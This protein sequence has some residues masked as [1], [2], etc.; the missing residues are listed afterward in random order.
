[1]SFPKKHFIAWGFICGAVAIIL[2][3][4][5]ESEKKID[6]LFLIKTSSISITSSEFSEELDLKRAAYPYNI[7]G[8]PEEYNEMVM[9]LIQSLS[10]ELV[11]LSAAVD[12]GV[13]IT[14]QEVESAEKEFKKAY[15]QDSF[16]QILLKNAISYSFWKKRFK[17]DMIV[18]KFIDQELKEKIEITSQDIVVFYKKY[19]IAKTREKGMNLYGLKKIEDGKDMISRLRSQK[20]QDHYDEWMQQL[21]KNYPVEINKEKLKIFLIDTKNRKG[22]ENEKEN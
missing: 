9:D 11:L 20:A 10:E 12:K 3:G 8:N 17:K 1:M 14:D 19:H 16:D 22:H 4:C 21:C 6:S 15:P 13:T 18:D 2:M 7:D 5:G